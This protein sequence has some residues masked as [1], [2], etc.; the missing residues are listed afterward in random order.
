MVLGA[1]CAHTVSTV[2]NYIFGGR[3]K[4]ARHTHCIEHVDGCAATALERQLFSEVGEWKAVPDTIYF[5][6]RAPQ[7][8]ECNVLGPQ[9]QTED[10]CN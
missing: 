6:A 9:Q 5:A 10:I 3:T 7:F 8:R 2:E 4:H 1:N